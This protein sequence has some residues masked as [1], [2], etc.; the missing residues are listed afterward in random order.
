MS[1]VLLDALSNL[2]SETAGG[3]TQVA[4]W[5][6]S[7]KFPEGKNHSA[8]FC[9]PNIGPDTRHMLNERFL[10]QWSNSP[11][12]RRN[13]DQHMT[14]IFDESKSGKRNSSKTKIGGSHVGE[15][16][17][18]WDAY[19]GHLALSSEFSRSQGVS[20]ATLQDT[21]GFPHWASPQLPQGRGSGFPSF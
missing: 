8:Y 18:M 14:Y 9:I 15:G 12:L 16:G 17:D 13:S 5:E 10:N 6:Y 1:V 3:E 19:T 2:S 7:S 20:C 4:R 21:Q 11:K